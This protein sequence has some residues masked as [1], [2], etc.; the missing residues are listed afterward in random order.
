MVNCHPRE[1]VARTKPTVW[2]N[3]EGDNAA[4][5][6]LLNTSFYYDCYAKLTRGLMKRLSVSTLFSEKKLY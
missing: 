2:V 5:S 4:L 3:V 6:P 1:T